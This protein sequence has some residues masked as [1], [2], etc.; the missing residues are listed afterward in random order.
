[1]VFF[2]KPSFRM[3]SET[4]DAE[5]ILHIYIYTYTY[6]CVYIYICVYTC[7]YVYRVK[8]LTLTLTLILFFCSRKRSLRWRVKHRTPRRYFIYV[9]IFI[10]LYMYL[11]LSTYIHMHVF[12]TIWFPR[13]CV[14][15]AFSDGGWN[16]GRREDASTFEA[17]DGWN[18]PGATNHVSNIYIYIY[19]Y[20]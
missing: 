5:K 4:P 14:A 10:S 16:T 13:L 11:Y 20:I 7:I 2:F 15:D 12:Q 1:M 8:G 3:E 17:T 18:G 9:N 19:I 6:I